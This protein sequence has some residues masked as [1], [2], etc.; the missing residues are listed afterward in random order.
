MVD[1][2]QIPV[3][4]KNRL[5]AVQGYRILNSLD[6]EDFDRITELASIICD[7]PISLISILD[8]NRQWFKSKVGLDVKETS[9]DLAFCQYAILDT[10]IFEI[11]DATLDVRF[12]ENA[13]VTG[14]PNIRF[15]AGFPLI[16]PDGYALGT[17]CV[18]DRKAK[19]L[20]SAQKKALQIL[21][22]ETTSLIVERAKN[23]D[24]KNF[25]HFFQLSSD[26]MGIAGMDGFFKQVNPAL[27]GSLG[28]D[29]HY[30][31]TTPFINL[32]HPDDVE[33]TISE[34][35]KLM[36][37]ENTVNFINRYKTSSNLY[38]TIQWT[39]ASELATGNIFCVG[40]DITLD[41]L[42]EEKLIANE[43]KLRAFFENSQG[44]MCTH[45]L[46]GNFLTV[47]DAGA[48][49]LG[50]TKDEISELSLFDI[51]PVAHHSFLSSY[52][53]N[54]INKGDERGQMVTM[55]K[56]GTTRVW[57]F[58]NVLERQRDGMLYVIGNAID[59]TEKH[60]LEKDLKR[61]KE[62]LEK[63]N[64]VAR[65][66][67]WESD[68]N[69]NTSIW[70]KAIYDIFEV[71]YDFSKQ[72]E[73]TLTLFKD[74][75]KEILI[76]AVNNAVTNGKK[77]DLELQLKKDSKWV[78][79][80]G[81]PI[82]G[83]GNDIATLKGV[84]IDINDHKLI[85]LALKDSIEAQ[86]ELNK[87]LIEQ[88]ELV[89]EQDHTIDKIKEFKFLADSI[90]QIIW[91]AEPDGNLDYYNQ[92]WFDYT[93]MTLEQTLGWGWEPV[94]HPDDL[95]NCIKVWTESFSTG[96]PYEVEY[97][98]KRAADGAY[99][100]HLGR[101]LPMR[102]DQGR[103]VKWF[104]SCTDI[105]EYKRALD[106]ENKI[107]QYEDFNRIVAHNLRGP[108]GSIGMILN[109]VDETNSDT[110]KAEF[111]GMLRQSSTTLNDTLDDLMKVMEVRNNKGMVYD[112][113]DLGK[114][115]HGIECMLKG[116]IFSKKAII[117]THFEARSIKFPKI[118]LES[119]FYNLVSNSLKY[120][121]ADVVPKIIITSKIENEKIILNFSDNGLGI[122]LKLHGENVFKLNKIFHR[123]FD[124]KGVGLFMTKTQIE[125]FGGKIMIE[126]EP[127]VGTT[128]TIIFNLIIN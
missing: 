89:I 52:L 80:V 110:E 90:P 64:A 70:T 49:L 105:D 15:Y 128:F 60:F 97:R 44:L 9:R 88:I 122:D 10:S 28:Y 32:V 1:T 116:Q 109:M 13:L 41:K 46:E 76:T 121:R 27:E 11:E 37:G 111:F 40:R 77:W 117:E 103:I 18:I 57:M 112:D 125:T 81:E 123:G 113:C 126:S 33:D 78:R 29:A 75:S 31:I 23:D 6:E 83:A 85:E 62:M 118:Y 102:N 43:E 96:K 68:F 66:G 56:D 53:S 84:F 17:L 55:H 25:E 8:E 22:K 48:T 73:E 99:K 36:E 59:I 51:V 69:N 124:S 114:V 38:K 100:W 93:G 127:N 65:V 7:V 92:H 104:G 21:A 47:N 4:E 24:L 50:Y 14:E 30:L 2:F 86:E 98:F 3:N 20:T 91:T 82:F 26:I 120:S 39:A 106:L 58:N 5:K 16:D 108:A 12:K 79:S 87:V 74:E 61:T 19:T 115:V 35:K 107:S 94:L 45:D 95:E 101:A 42:K 63:T 72:S 34:V 71:D 119:I 67:G 54:I